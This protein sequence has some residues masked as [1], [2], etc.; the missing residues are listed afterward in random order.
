MHRVDSFLPVVEVLVSK[1]L[2]LSLSLL[3]SQLF[4]LCAAFV[5]AKRLILTKRRDIE[6]SWLCVVPVILQSTPPVFATREVRQATQD[7][8]Y[9]C[10]NFVFW[11]VEQRNLVIYPFPEIMI[12]LA[13]HLGDVAV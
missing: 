2:K 9:F 13:V 11:V 3:M 5:R 6:L 7:P 12:S 10:P 8:V 1:M 4:I